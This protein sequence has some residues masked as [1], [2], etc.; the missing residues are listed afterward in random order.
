MKITNKIRF[1]FQLEYSN[2]GKQPKI[3]M[4][5]DPV[6]D[7]TS[8]FT[9]LLGVEEGNGDS[10]PNLPSR[11]FYALIRGERSE[12]PLLMSSHRGGEVSLLPRQTDR[13]TCL[14]GVLYKK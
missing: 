3:T 1:S 5:A 2:S 14:F 8:F 6:L 13:E 7:V 10:V 9:H 11:S 12:F 4:F